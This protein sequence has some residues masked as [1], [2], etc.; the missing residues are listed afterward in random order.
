MRP[1]ILAFVLLAPA[2]VAGCAGSE[3]QGT[4]PDYVLAPEDR[5]T[6][7]METNRGTIEIE[8]YSDMAPQTVQNFGQL[9]VDGFY[10]DV[11]FHR[12]I[13]GFMIQGGDPL[14]AEEGNRDRWG[15]GGPGY[16]ILDEFPCR[17]GSI[18][19]VHPGR[20]YPARQP[21]PQCDDKG[22]FAAPHDGPGVLSMANSGPRSGGSQFFITLT[23]T[24]HLDGKHS[25]FGQVTEGMDVVETIGSTETDQR[26]RPVEDIIIGS[27]T[28]EGDLP[29]VELQTFET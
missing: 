19:H 26:D 10:D 23:A 2:L 7:V 28:I 18:S 25:V 15:T 14:T 6:A 21:G 8:L 20:N 3:E 4:E 11:R 16:S 12:V 29:G 1:A 5:P 22:G 9:A 13:D 17:D 24:H 27:I